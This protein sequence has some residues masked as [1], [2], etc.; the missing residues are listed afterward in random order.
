MSKYGDE[1]F[2]DRAKAFWAEY[3][4]MLETLEE[5]YGVEYTVGGDEYDEDVE[6]S[7]G[8]G[9]IGAYNLRYDND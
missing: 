9:Y 7:R 5:K 2:F 8:R 1:E 6:N 3:E 4:P